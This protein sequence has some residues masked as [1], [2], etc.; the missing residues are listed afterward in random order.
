MTSTSL[1]LSQQNDLRRLSAL[2][3]AVRA[4][5]AG[6]PFFVAGATARDM[7]LWYARQIPTG[8]ATKDVDIAVAVAGWTEFSEFKGRLLQREADPEGPLRLVG[9]LRGDP[10]LTLRLVRAAARGASEAA[11]GEKARGNRPQDS[12][13]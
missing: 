7:L 4:G 9:D 5:A 2:I 3:A 10:D 1:D 11:D 13:A 8:R 6:I 12:S